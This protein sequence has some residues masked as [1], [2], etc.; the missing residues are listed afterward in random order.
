MCIRDRSNIANEI[1]EY[2]NAPCIQGRIAKRPGT[3]REDC[4]V[5]DNATGAS[6]LACADTANNGLC[7]RTVAGAAACGG[8]VSVS[9]EGSSSEDIT[10]DCTMCVPGMPD[11]S[12]GCP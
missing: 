9:V 10:V 12:R 1:V 5:T 4:T 8:G 3:T 6:V 11:P 7:W 2:V